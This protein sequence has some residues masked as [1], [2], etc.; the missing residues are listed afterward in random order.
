[1]KKF[2]ILLAMLS[3]SLLTYAQAPVNDVCS[4]ATLITVNGGAI[5]ANNSNTVTNGANPSCGGTTGIKD[6]WYKFVYTGG[7]VVVE[8]QLCTNTDTR[9]AVYTA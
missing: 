4:T 6:I 2:Y 3:V 5:A 7:T 8:T 9:L 1:M